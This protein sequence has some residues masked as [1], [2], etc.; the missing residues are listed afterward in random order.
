M[1]N[2]GLVF[3]ILISFAPGYS[4]GQTG[5]TLANP[6]VAG[7]FSSVFQ[8]VNS[9][10]TVNFTNE[11][12]GRPAN[13]VFY[14]FT[15]TEATTVTI[16]H[17]GSTL[18]DTYLHLL[19]ASGNRIAYNDDYSGE[20]RCANIYHSYLK[21][22]LFA[23]TYYVVSESY[24]QNGVILT[25]IKGEAVGPNDVL[26]GSISV[27]SFAA[28]FQY[29]NSQNTVN[30]QNHLG[31]HPNEALYKF[32]LTLPMEITVNHC[33]STLGD[34]YLYLLDASGNIIDENDDYRYEGQCS[35]T[36]HSYL[37][38]VLPAGS[39]YVVSEGYSQ[40]G[41]I[42]TSIR[43][44]TDIT[45]NTLQKP[46][47]IASSNSSFR[48][49]NSQNTLY[50]TNNHTLRS[51]ND[52]F[53]K[54][55]LTSLMEVTV[56]HCG[57]TLQDTYLHLLDASGNRIAYNDDYYGDG[58]CSSNYHSLLKKMLPVG[59]YY[60]VSEGYSQNGVIR[61]TVEG[62][63]PNLSYSY[64]AAGNRTSRSWNSG[65]VYLRAAQSKPEEKG[66]RNVEEKETEEMI[67]LGSEEEIASTD[68]ALFPNPTRGPLTVE[69]SGYTTEIQGEIR[70]F[71]SEGQ[72]LEHHR[73]NTALTYLDLS[74]Y[75]NGVYLLQIQVNGEIVSRKIIKE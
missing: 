64:D 6:I 20:G 65:V 33:G 40:N 22:V 42:R 38:T 50:F 26:P 49:E 71:N 25:T 61:T 73:L 3:T 2:L 62:K 32:T 37:R 75:P 54:F 16:S 48:Y 12:V 5:N 35:N 53:Y 52:V 19:D 60:V 67:L 31:G 68:I 72:S 7:S 21:K 8:Y 51:A 23:G 45:G 43:G 34:T 28:S 59:V 11:Y 44:E 9:Q 24:L 70:L 17:C 18:P 69:V 30:L 66:D 14:R 47:V 74:A 13:D 57:S 46:I 41:T 29:E 10:N 55:T 4:Y 1:K 27:G 39:Y 58:Q 56:S 63:L 15:L 36:L